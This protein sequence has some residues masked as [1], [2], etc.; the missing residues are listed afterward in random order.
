MARGNFDVDA[1]LEE[2]I[3]KESGNGEHPYSN[4]PDDA[5]GETM[6]GWTKSAARDYGYMG[7]MRDLTRDQAKAMYYSR[8]YRRPRFDKVAEISPLIAGELTE[9]GINCGT[10]TAVK[11]LQKWLSNFND[12]QR[13]YVDLNP[14]G[15]IGSK[16]M[17]AL[18]AY[19]RERDEK[20]LHFALNAEQTS[21]YASLKREKYLYGWVKNRAYADIVKANK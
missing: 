13:I 8:Y 16:T 19:L 18:R 5:G 11:F 3:D 12:D 9:C 21:Y 14:D 7:E 6:W 2:I 20:V 15:G 1:A 4:D 17:D 10:V